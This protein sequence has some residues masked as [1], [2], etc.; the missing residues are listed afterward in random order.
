MKKIKQTV[1]TLF[2]KF[3][4]HKLVFAIAIFTSGILIGT[5]LGWFLFKTP[6]KNNNHSNTANETTNTAQSLRNRLAKTYSANKETI[7]AD[8]KSGKIT[9]EQ[10]DLITKKLNEYYEYRKS[11]VE[12]DDS[13]NVLR[14]K[15]QEM[16]KWA[17]DNK[18]SN[19]YFVGIL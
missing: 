5:L 12:N 2:H 3:S 10:A 16:R 4:R 15:R 13:G 6:G 18:V 8:V 11:I 9:K 14:Q 7:L 17:S 19:K 1:S